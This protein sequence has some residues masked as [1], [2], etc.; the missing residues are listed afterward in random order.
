[1][2]T[3]PGNTLSEQDI[4]PRCDLLG[5]SDQF[6]ASLSPDGEKLAFIT[7]VDGVY[8]LMVASTSRFQEATS[9][10]RDKHHPFRSI[11]WARNG[12]QLLVF[13]D[14]G[15]NENCRLEIVTLEP[16]HSFSFS[17]SDDADVRLVAL[18]DTLPDEILIETN[19]RN[20]AYFDIY[21]LNLGDGSSSLIEL[22]N[23]FTW[24][25]A[26]HYLQP[27]LAESRPITGGLDYYTYT[28]QGDWQLL[29]SVEDEDEHSTRP[30]RTWETL[31]GFSKNADEIYALD[32]RNRDTAA[33][34]AWN[35]ESG[36]SRIIACDPN[37]D[38]AGIVVDQDSHQVIGYSHIYDRHQIIAIGDEIDADISALAAANEDDE[39]FILSQSR[40]SKVWLIGRSAPDLPFRYEL[41]HRSSKTLQ[42]VIETKPKLQR[43]QLAHSTAHTL[44]ARDKL[45]LLAYLTLPNN[46]SGIDKIANP[47]PLVAIVH[48]G[49][50]IRDTYSFDPWD[51]LLANRGYAVLKVNFRASSGFGKTFLNAGNRQWGGKI[52][53]DVIDAVQWA[54]S[55]GI[56]DPA[57]LAIMGAS[58]GGYTTLMALCRYPELFTC[59]IDLFGP[60]NLQSFLDS[61]PAHWKAHHAMW[62]R[63]VGST[64][65]AADRLQLRDQSP[66]YC[67]DKIISPVLI[68]QGG[69]D[70]R[71]VQS[72]ST[73][74]AEALQHHG[75]DVTY[76]TYP[77]EGHG[78]ENSTNRLAFFGIV[79]AFLAQ[80]LGGY[81]EPLGN[82]LLDSTAE[83]RMGKQHIAGVA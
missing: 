25:Y 22:N 50:W 23:R 11:H 39:T 19:D 3:T 65:S 78:F 13:R 28:S 72:E 44:F 70:P 9:I 63:R 17:K 48:G 38:I 45:P 30:F 29:F 61:I 47:V 76:V 33:L 41:Y 49:P 5:P 75:V 43:N 62:D 2:T 56:A 55:K 54:V 71:V 64:K 14:N 57:K 40:D 10:I 36:H 6:E 66:L 69:N 24:I 51:Q 53:D 83:I 82:E 15:G 4:I 27:R 67:V 18:S 42:T 52:C 35:L 34:A 1:M 80:H 26:D 37:T 7:A 32:S 46:I 68:G 12:E 8:N 59:G 60:T 20:S 74:M 77:D 31:T 21:R 58:F 79:E 73:Q 16:F 81:F